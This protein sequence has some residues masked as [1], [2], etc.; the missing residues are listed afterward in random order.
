MQNFVSE[1][2]LFELV[3]TCQVHRYSKTC[4]KYRND[5]CRFNFGKIFTDR[6]IVAE[7][8]PDD[9]PEEIKNQVL[10]NRSDLLSKGK[11]YIGTELN[12][13]IKNFY[14]STRSDYEVVK[15]IVEILSLLEISKEDYETALSISEDS[16]YQLYLKIPPN[17]CFVNNYFTDGLLAWETNTDI[18]P[19]LITTKQLH[20]CVPISPKATMSFLRP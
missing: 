12:P 11:R 10:K 16:D 8:L 4:R 17:S 14:D 2:E 20:I 1:K 19:V 5:K 7:P 3:K 9:M 15:N 18:Q 6:T 13:S